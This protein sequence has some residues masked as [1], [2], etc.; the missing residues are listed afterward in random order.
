M[1]L[2]LLLI[3]IF[4]G[5]LADG[6]HLH[7]RG[8]EKPTDMRVNIRE[9][10]PGRYRIQKTEQEWKEML[11]PDAYFILRQS[12]TERPFTGRYY[13]NTRTGIYFSAATGQPL[14]ISD[15]Q[16]D[17]GCG[18][19]SFFEPILPDAVYYRTDKSFGMIRT[20]V[21][22]S[23]S[24]SHLG[25][26]FDDGPPPTGLRY[27]MNSEAMVFVGAGEELPAI[28]RKYMAELA[29]EE[30]KEAVDRFLKGIRD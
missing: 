22:D 11:L 23:G 19:P 8:H 20:E 25:H 18:W 17:S 5:P 1:A 21:I 7:A 9:N 3:L 14:F 2:V 16:F 6:V 12:G 10:D 26:V 30:E 15:T 28:V 29:S 4:P 13:D 24:G 27:C